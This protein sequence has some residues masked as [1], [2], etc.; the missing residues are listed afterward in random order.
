MKPIGIDLGTTNSA[1]SVYENGVA[2]TLVIEG[3]QTTPSVVYIEN[4]NVTVGRQAKKRILLS[5]KNILSST[6]RDIGTSWQK[7][8]EGKNYSAVFAASAILKYL[9][10]EAEKVINDKIKEVVITVPA[11]FNSEQKADTKKAAEEAGL[12]V[13]L[14]SAEPTAAAVAY[15]IEK[16][17]INQ[18]LAVIDLGGGT[19]DVSLVEVKNKEYNVK[20]V[21]GNSK[22]GGD[23]FDKAIVNYLLD[24]INDTFSVD[25]RNNEIVNLKL[26]EEA[27]IIKKELSSSLS[28]AINIAGLYEGVNIDIDNFTRDQYKALIQ[29]YLDEILATIK[30]VIQQA[31]MEKDDINRFVLVG[32][33]CKSP[34]VLKL[35][36]DNYK[37]PYV[38]KDVD[39]EVSRGAAII[40]NSLLAP[41][42]YTS[43]NEKAPPPIIINESLPQSLGI[44]V[45]TQKGG[46]FKKTKSSFIPILKRNTHYPQKGAYLAQTQDKW[47][48]SVN[49]TVFR[50]EDDDP[51]KNEKIGTL[52]MK[53]SEK[54]LGQDV[55]PLGCIFS[56]DKNGIL[57]FSMIE[58][59][60]NSDNLLEFTIIV[61]KAI[62]NN[63]Y[64]SFEI[65]E[66][67]A[68]Q[69]NFNSKEVVINTVNK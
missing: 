8:I 24:Y 6:K 15:G 4:N 22:L 44:N 13:K 7:D 34:I 59:P 62:N 30:S 37:E 3:H 35:I 50:G 16:E 68:K 10:T 9:V 49:V 47:Q 21:G 64:I 5:P 42:T 51:E 1:I 56:I 17:N 45:L 69:N 63:G 29:P 25:L 39:T 58:M 43:N 33:S 46:L 11:Y 52:E 53:I 26:K 60:I 65:L 41:V 12:D 57:S 19:F 18:T 54:L 31:N 20:A 23:D 48:Q 55:T 67:Y 66:E 40:C 38:A 14:L 32:G 2:T 28:V 36:T 27:E 61:D